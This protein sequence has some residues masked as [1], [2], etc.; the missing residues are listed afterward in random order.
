MMMSRWELCGPGSKDGTL[1]KSYDKMTKSFVIQLIE[2]DTCIRFPKSSN[3]LLNNNYQMSADI[4]RLES[5]LKH[6]QGSFI[7]NG[8]VNSSIE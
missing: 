5:H 4:E 7:S 1:I 2:R 8:G 3:F 6:T